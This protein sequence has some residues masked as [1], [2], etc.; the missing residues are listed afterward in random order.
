MLYGAA[1]PRRHP[2][3]G[4]QASDRNSSSARSRCR[5]GSF[6][7]IQG[8]FDVGGPVDKDKTLLYRVTGI[9]LNANTQVDHIGEERLRSRRPGPGG[10]IST[11]PS[12]S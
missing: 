4:E 5:T 6:D 10:R 2:Q 9:G 3:H 7:R 12:P 8:A 1:S 11:P